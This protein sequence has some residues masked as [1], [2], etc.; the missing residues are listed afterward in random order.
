MSSPPLPL[1][2]LRWSPHPIHGQKRAPR[3]SASIRAVLLAISLYRI[4]LGCWDLPS[5]TFKPNNFVFMLVGSD[6][7]LGELHFILILQVRKLRHKALRFCLRL[8][9]T[10]IG[11]EEELFFSEPEFGRQ[12]F[13]KSWVLFICISSIKSI[14]SK[15]FIHVGVSA[16]H[17]AIKWTQRIVSFWFKKKI[18]KKKALR[19]SKALIVSPVY[20]G[21]PGLVF[22]YG[23]S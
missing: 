11:R 17:Q 9:N 13:H 23:S 6:H 20:W 4:F 3:F 10:V 15:C 1:R 2:P 7:Q 12:F 16:K 14:E 18:K 21:Y 8:H 5:F 19:E 22:W